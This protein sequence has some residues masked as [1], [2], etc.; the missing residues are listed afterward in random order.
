LKHFRYVAIDKK[1][2]TVK[3]ETDALSNQ[4]VHS[5]LEGNGVYP[6]S[7]EEV[8]IP[9]LNLAK[10][11]F[12]FG[13][14]KQEELIIFTEQFATLIS[15][16]L[17]I[18]DSLDGLAEQTENRT[19]KTVILNIRADIE[20]GISLSNAFKKYNRIFPEIYINLLAVGEA[21][22]NLDKVLR[23]IAGYLERDLSVRRKIASAFAYPRFVII[24][25]IAVVIFLVSFILPQ[26]V[27]IY[28]QAGE[29][30]PTP[31]KILLSISNFIR[32]NY[33]ILIIFAVLIYAG[34]RIFYSTK[35]G[36]LFIDRYKLDIPVFGKINKMG[37]LSRFL[38]SF[39]LVIGSGINLV[40]AI[41]VS[42]KVSGNAYLV[43]ELEEVR[44]AIIG[45][46]SLSAAVREIKF[47]PNIMSQ[48]VSVGERSGSLDSMLEK[49]ADL[50]DK[51]IDYMIN[52]LSARI[53]P[54]LIIILA[55][56]VGFVALAMY[57]PMF[58]LPSTYQ[59]TL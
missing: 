16:G 10:P 7:I 19:L 32:N 50:W 54:T 51:D 23:S 9:R 29:E 48:M 47:F 38:H 59:K 30:L 39:A 8:S 41:D 52:T 56:I 58:S 20:R 12:S 11:N 53:E 17:S 4:E 15:S 57:L 35:T 5:M 34:Y 26:F 13:R 45:G 33:L 49:L 44:G 40:E 25:V 37:V 43:K 1:G 46:E 2:R 18:V 28:T 55:F 3:G 21:T 24:V 6:I 42:S 27:S 31:T 22:G 14:V 36:K